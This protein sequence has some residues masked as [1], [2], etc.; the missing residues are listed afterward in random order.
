[1]WS[2]GSCHLM[3]QTIL[4]TRAGA[5]GVKVAGEVTDFLP[6]HSVPCTALYMDLNDWQARSGGCGQ[7]NNFKS[8]KS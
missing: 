3:N 8:L 7:E 4:A 6:H 2:I 1:M 5:Q